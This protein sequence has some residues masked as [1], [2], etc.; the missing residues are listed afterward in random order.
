MLLYNV[1]ALFFALIWQ[2]A[3]LSNEQSD[4][5]L[6]EGARVPLCTLSFVTLAGSYFFVTRAVR[7]GGVDV[8]VDMESFR[9][10]FVPFVPCLGILFTV[11]CSRNLR[12]VHG[13]RSWDIGLA[14]ITYFAY[15]YSH[16]VGGLTGWKGTLE[17][18]PYAVRTFMASGEDGCATARH[19]SAKMA[20]RWVGTHHF[21]SRVHF[22]T[23]A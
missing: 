6:P 7:A 2:F 19:S 4:T 1:C 10:P 20:M 9:A 22:I 14:T 5:K 3:F 18:S 17:Y 13:S 23:T 16:S 21:L 8:E 12:L 15:G 11:S